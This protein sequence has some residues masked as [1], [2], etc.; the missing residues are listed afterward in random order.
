MQ[1][2]KSMASSVATMVMAGVM[3]FLVA[4]GKDGDGFLYEANFCRYLDAV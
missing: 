1:F 2:L 4:I 3:L